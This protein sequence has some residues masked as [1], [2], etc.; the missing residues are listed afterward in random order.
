MHAL[1]K[2]LLFHVLTCLGLN[3]DGSEIINGKKVEEGSMQYMASLQNNNKEHVCGGFLIREDVVVTAAHCD[4]A[5]FTSVVLGT[6][7]LKK[8]EEEI[9]SDIEQRYKHKDYRGVAYGNDIMLLKLSQGAG[10]D[11]RVETIQL[12]TSEMNTNS[13]ETCSVAGWG[14]T[15]RGAVDDL[16]VV[17]LSIIK[18]Q[19]CKEQW[20]RVDHNLP[21]NVI[22]AGG[23]ETDKGF[24]QGDSG[25]PLVCNGKAVGVVSYN[26]RENCNYPDVPNVYLDLYK[27][28]PWIKSI[29]GDMKHYE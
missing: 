15:E 25:G 23:Y 3:A 29:L 2:F 19:V 17:N 9:R 6:H 8:K 14:I 18:L 10:P 27:Y 20:L 16:R 1:H 26:R 4:D 13:K 22:C 12:P 11:N 24:C 28:L 5:G 21:A 7:D